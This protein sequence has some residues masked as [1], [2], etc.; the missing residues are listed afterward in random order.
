M[1]NVEQSNKVLKKKPNLPRHDGV[2]SQRRAEAAQYQ[3][4]PQLAHIQA[5]SPLGNSHGTNAHDNRHEHI[6]S[7][8]VQPVVASLDAPALVA[9]FV[10]TP[11]LG[12]YR[13]ARCTSAAQSSRVDNRL[14]VAKVGAACGFGRARFSRSAGWF[15]GARVDEHLK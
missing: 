13:R 10:G 6:H 14:C 7:V 11:W 3:L 8:V 12:P 1:L 5:P 9:F 4:Y 2:C 15:C